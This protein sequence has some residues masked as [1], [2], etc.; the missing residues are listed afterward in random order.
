MTEG[1]P[2]PQIIRFSVPLALTGILQLLFNAADVIVVGKFAGSTSLAAV[3]ATSALVNL[4]TGAFIGI[5]VGVNILVARYAGCRD[6][7]RV[8]RAVHSAIA[9]SLVLGVVTFL[10]G[11]FLSTPML[12]WMDTPDDVLALA[13]LYLRIYFI[14]IPGALIY[15]FAAAILRAYGDTKRPLIFLAISGVLNVFLNLFFVIVC[16]LD[17]AGVAIATVVSQYVAVVLILICLVRQEGPAKLKLREIRLHPDEALRMIQIGLPAGLQSVVFNIS[18]VMVQS[19]VNSFGADVIAANTA[20]TNIAAFT[21]TAMNSVF[22]A[23]ITFTSQNL[24][25]R[26]YDRV[27]K[28]FWACQATVL[29]IGIPLCILSTVFGPQLL[30]IYV[31]AN[32]PAYDSVIAMGLIRTYY[33]TTPYFLCGIMEVCCGM[34]RGLGKSWLP[35]IVTIFGACILRIIWIYTIFAWD[36]TL[37][38]LYISYP[39]SWVV[40]AAMHAVRPEF[41]IRPLIYGLPDYAAENFVRTDLGYNHGRP[42]FATVGSFE[43]RK[44][45]DIF[46][47]AIRLLPPEVREKASFLFVGQAADKEM[48]D[49]VRTLTADYPENVYYCKRLTRDEIKSL[50]E[51]CTGLVCASRDDPMPTF[52]TEGLIFGKPSI[53]SEHTGTAGLISEGRN[54]FVYHNDDP[55]QLAVLLEHAIEHPEELAS[56]RTEC[57]KM[58]EQYYSKEAF[59]QTLRAAVEDLTAKK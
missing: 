40:T 43:R 22:H 41:E 7:A 56:M 4:L 49:S 15:N 37:P 55:Q 27:M 17:V 13:S 9:L 39:I 47:K 44:G 42:L 30:S 26:R 31:S 53:V 5:S 33:V 8:G 3:G 34:V 11:F 45:H 6:D 12:E 58:Y 16:E 50:M 2:L 20:A 52:V 29:L 14:G 54:G 24:G 38:A 48:M 51:Q 36:H 28:I 19:C 46:C 1:S 25:A 32:D 59:E 21:Y 23:S 10:L 35:M 57:R 18:N